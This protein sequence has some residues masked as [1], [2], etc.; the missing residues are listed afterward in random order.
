MEPGMVNGNG[1]GNQTWVFEDD[2]SGDNGD[3]GGSGGDGGS[4]HSGGGSNGGGGGGGPRHGDAH[5]I[6][7]S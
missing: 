2:H 3:H 6:R 4:S 5:S 7:S 1:T